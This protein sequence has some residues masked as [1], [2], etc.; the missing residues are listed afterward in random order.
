[1]VH[2]AVTTKL[3]NIM[4]KIF[5]VL[6]TCQVSRIGVRLTDE[7]TFEIAKKIAMRTSW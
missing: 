5:A 6:Q 2:R 3:N 1:M 7:L 4:D